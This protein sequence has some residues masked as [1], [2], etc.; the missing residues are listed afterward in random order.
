MQVKWLREETHK[1]EVVS[2]NPGAGDYMDIF[3]IN[4]LHKIVLFDCKD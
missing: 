4:L 1:Q 2:L 3:H